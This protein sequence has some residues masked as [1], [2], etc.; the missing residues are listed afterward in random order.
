[1]KKINAKPN[2]ISFTI[3]YDD[4]VVAHYSK[5]NILKKTIFV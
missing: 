4:L 5:T 2:D 3:F 1:M